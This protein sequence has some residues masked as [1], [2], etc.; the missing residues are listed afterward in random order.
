MF[1]KA[2]D[3]IVLTDVTNYIRDKLPQNCVFY[4]NPC[5]PFYLDADPYDDASARIL[6]RLNDAPLPDASIIVWDNIFS[7]LDHNVSL[8]ML[9]QD[10]RFEE[11]KSWQTADGA[12]QFTIF[13]KRW[14]GTAERSVCLETVLKP[15][16]LFLASL[17]MRAS[18]NF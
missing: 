13:K 10:A 1:V 14:N 18:K 15:Y 11:I 3:Q 8:E 2:P 9:R 6:R 12:F 17:E 5:V 4:S 16:A 7:V